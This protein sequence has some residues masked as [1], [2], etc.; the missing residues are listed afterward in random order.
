MIGFALAIFDYFPNTFSIT[1][2]SGAIALREAS[3]RN[4]RLM[5]L[6]L[7]VVE[8]KLHKQFLCTI[9]LLCSLLAQFTLGLLLYKTAQVDA[10]LLSSWKFFEK[11]RFTFPH[12][13]DA[14]R[15]EDSH[16][17]TV[18]DGRCWW[19]EKEN[20]EFR[21]V[22][23]LTHFDATDEGNRNTTESGPW[24]VNFRWLLCGAKMIAL[25]RRVCRS[26]M[27]TL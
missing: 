24:S 2:F 19:A 20:F 16:G 27:T 10:L 21:N 8:H 11:R 7:E 23:G 13:F 6:P 18:T 26:L 9:F 5:A 14:L 25:A 22:T 17:S 15:I 12:T 3:L 4:R 1:A